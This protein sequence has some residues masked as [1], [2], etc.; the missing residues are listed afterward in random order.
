MTRWRLF[1]GGG[2]SCTASTGY[3]S[4]SRPGVLLRPGPTGRFDQ[5]YKTRNEFGGEELEGESNENV[6]D[7]GIGTRNSAGAGAEN[8][9]GRS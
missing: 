9:A 5:G 3:G 2:R 1:A 8:P 4:C 7:G 6:A